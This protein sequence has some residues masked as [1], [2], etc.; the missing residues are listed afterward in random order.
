MGKLRSKASPAALV[1]SVIAL[2]AA[3]GGGAA[4][5]LPGKNTIDSGDIKKNAVKSSDIK[6]DKVTGTDVKESTLSL[7][8]SAVPKNTFG[9]SVNSGGSVTAATLPGTKADISGAGAYT[10][11]FPRSVQGCV[12]VA[13]TDSFVAAPASAVLAGAGSPNVVNVYAGNGT[14]GYNVIVTC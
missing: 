11:T 7:P 10:V 9:A 3:I 5:A 1:I 12:P 6:N 14:Q 2:I 4:I 8:A 13:S